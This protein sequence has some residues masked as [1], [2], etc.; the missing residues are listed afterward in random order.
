MEKDWSF[1][2]FLLPRLFQGEHDIYIAFR[3][4]TPRP[5]VTLLATPSFHSVP[6]LRV[7]DNTDLSKTIISE[8]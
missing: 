8:T 5:L 3:S 1:F 6:D 2:S 7:F 4:S